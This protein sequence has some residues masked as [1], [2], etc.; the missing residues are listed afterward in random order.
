MATIARAFESEDQAREAMHQLISRGVPADRM[1][2]VNPHADSNSAAAGLRAGSALAA[3]RDTE[4]YAKA[5]DKGQVLVLVEPYFGTAIRMSRVM[6]DCSP[7]PLEMQGDWE[8]P[9]HTA[10]PLSFMLGL[11]VLI[12]NNPAPFSTFFSFA[13]KSRRKTYFVDDLVD[14][15]PER[16]FGFRTLTRQGKPFFGGKLLSTWREK[17]RSFGMPL[18]TEKATILGDTRLSDNPAPLS[19][20]YRIPTLTR[21]GQT[22]QHH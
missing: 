19:G 21:S 17:N 22:D 20:L 10:S 6:D 15:S 8:D 18:L 9:L 5:L 13:T 14:S 3:H 12:R 1:Q 11:P 2:L 16:S 7:C 4:A